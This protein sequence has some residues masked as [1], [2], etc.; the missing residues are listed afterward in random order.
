MSSP[1]DVSVNFLESSGKLFRYYKS[2]G[3]KAIA[4]LTDKQINARPNAASNSIAHIVHHLSG[5]MLSR[6]T[7]F[8][9]ADGEKSWRNRE[10]EFA[11]GYA[12]KAELLAAWEKGWACLFTALDSLQPADLSRIIYIR[13]E[14]QTVLE[15]IQRQLAHYPHHV[16]QILYQAKA[17]VGDDF[18]S[19]SIARGATEQFNK[20]KFSQEKTRKH[21]TDG[22]K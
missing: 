5:N 12:T 11:E 10:A 2:L 20:D 13:N 9:T 1:I 7:D 19:L 17:L 14:G 3:E 4:Q 8:L 15:A 18:R 22:M 21:F 16:G 6:F